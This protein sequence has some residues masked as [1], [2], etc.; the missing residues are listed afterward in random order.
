MLESAWQVIIQFAIWTGG[1]L[2]ATTALSENPFNR[3]SPRSWYHQWVNDLQNEEDPRRQPFVLPLWLCVV[4][5]V[6]SMIFFEVAF[7][8][9]YHN[10]GPNNG[11]EIHPLPLL[12]AGGSYLIYT[13]WVVILLATKGD[14]NVTF[15]QILG[16]FFGFIALGLMVQVPHIGHNGWFLIVFIGWQ[17]FLTVKIFIE[18]YYR[19]K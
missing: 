18:N 13:G 19:K 14:C 7:F 10:K 1:T 6:V 16:I 15:A 3:K 2:V 12:A 4:F 11:L 9:I 17:I 5:H 8:I